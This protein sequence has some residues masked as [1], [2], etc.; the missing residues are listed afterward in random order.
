MHI[1]TLLNWIKPNDFKFDAVEY[2][3]SI[4]FELWEQDQEY[5]VGVKFNGEY[6]SIGPCKDELCRYDKWSQYLNEISY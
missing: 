3:S 4:I 6:L 2:S 1:A 5:Y